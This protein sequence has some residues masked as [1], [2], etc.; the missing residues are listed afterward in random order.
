MSRYGRQRKHLCEKERCT[1]QLCSVRASGKLLCNLG[2]DSPFKYG[3]YF[4]YDRGQNIFT[5]HFWDEINDSSD[6][7][8][9]NNN[10]FAVYVVDIP[11]DVYWTYNW[12]KQDIQNIAETIDGDPDEMLL[13]GKSEDVA[14]RARELSNIAATHGWDRFDHP[15]QMT[16]DDL[17]ARYGRDYRLFKLAENQLRNRWSPQLELDLDEDD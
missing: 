17:Q 12:A 7:G 10:K 8:D 5:G 1:S 6:D 2:D 16:H 14:V 11:N 15:E 4:I 9:P 13:N 3:G